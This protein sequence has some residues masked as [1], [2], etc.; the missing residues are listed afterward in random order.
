MPRS[1]INSL[2]KAIELFLIII[3]QFASD[4]YSL[5]YRITDII[6]YKQVYK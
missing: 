1:K 5:I 3:G 4:I 6:Y 2:I